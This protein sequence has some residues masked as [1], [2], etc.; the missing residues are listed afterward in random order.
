[1][2]RMK[3]LFALLLAVVM[4][5]GL[6]V[7]AFAEPQGYGTITVTNATVG[8]DY[9]GYKIFDVT[10]SDDAIAYTIDDE[11]QFYNAVNGSDS[12][13]ALSET[14]VSGVYNV[15]LKS[16]ETETTVG[17]W[18]N[19]LDVSEFDEQLGSQT[20]TT[21][22]VKWENV[23]YGYYLITSTLGSVVTVNQNTPNIEIIDKNQEPGTS[24]E[25]IVNENDEVVQIGVPFNFTLTFDATNYDGKTKIENYTIKDTFPEGMD[26]VTGNNNVTIEIDDDPNS[27]GAEHTVY[28]TVTLDDTRQLTIN[29]D[30]VGADPDKTSLYTS[31]ATVKVTYQAVLNSDAVIEG[32]GMI[33][34]AELTWTGNPKGNEASSTE[35]VYTYAIAIKKVNKDSQ[36]L[37]GATFTLRDVNGNEVKVS[38]VLGQEGVY[39][40]DPVGSATLTS[41]ASGL[42]VIKGVDNTKYTLTETKAPN[43]YNLLDEDVDVTP[44]CT[45]ETKTDTTIYLDAEGNVTSKETAVT[46]VE[47]EADIPATA[48]AVLNVAGTTL[49]S[50]GGMGT[51]LIYI[52]G[53]VLVIGA[54]VL[55]V[56][57]RRMNA[58]R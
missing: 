46:T 22:E 31:P 12:P 7:T 51:T 57:R 53:A 44:V 4:M 54:G 21:D 19:K 25:K 14:T 38:Q 23:P 10:Y 13:F 15:T 3:K 9:A 24:F 40:V 30:W 43:G 55:L 45:G 27:E 26:L 17:Q 20:A 28:D 2:K 58:E 6:S 8:K 39:V 5:M 42:I 33:N 48:V 1:M 18:M 29:I 32:A 34:A 36:A 41:P 56:V 50:T 47:I 16:G 37:A 52:A 11:N 35:T 49:P